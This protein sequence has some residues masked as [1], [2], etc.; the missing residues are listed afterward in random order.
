[1]GSIELRKLRNAAIVDICEMYETMGVCQKGEAGKIR[2]DRM[3]QDIHIHS[4]YSYWDW[5]QNLIK[6]INLIKLQNVGIVE[7]WEIDESMDQ[8]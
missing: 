5:T 4:Y 1:M 3:V 7:V 2:D 6:L 8:L